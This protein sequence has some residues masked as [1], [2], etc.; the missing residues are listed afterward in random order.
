MKS[1]SRLRPIFSIGAL[2]FCT[3]GYCNSICIANIAACTDNSV[4]DVSKI[5]PEPIWKTFLATRQAVRDNQYRPPTDQQFALSMARTF[6]VLGGIDEPGNLAEQASGLT[7][8]ESTRK[9]LDRAWSATGID[10]SENPDLVER[11]IVESTLAHSSNRARFITAKEYRV[12]KQ[13]SEN[14]YVG[15]GIQVMFDAPYTKIAMPFPRGTAWDAGIKK[16]DLILAVDDQSMKG[17]PLADVIDNLRG[18]EGSKVKVKVRNEDSDDE[19]EY[20]IERKVIPIDTVVGAR[21]EPGGTWDYAFEASGTVA[22]LRFNSIIGST[23]A[24]VKTISNQLQQDGFKAVVMDFRSI[25]TVEV[26]HLRLLAD[27]LLGEGSIG[28]VKTRESTQELKTR[29]DRVLID[30]PIVVLVPARVPGPL[31]LMLERLQATKRALLVG[32]VCQSDLICTK[33]IELPGELGAITDMPY[34]RCEIHKD[35]ALRAEQSALSSSGLQV[36]LPPR[37]K[38]DKVVEDS[39]EQIQA[40]MLLLK[41]ELSR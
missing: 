40:A 1:N 31:F 34:A 16:N 37:L 12:Q 23:A 36:A 20:T 4:Q 14:Q 6:Y 5:V 28:S 11:A 25:T 3:V 24:E 26:H 33:R 21:M 15:I 35:S 2:L 41:E 13:L 22:Y 17:V 27:T 38:P 29:V 32:P 39:D 10:M 19:R 8:D 7:N 30:V 18:S 9:F